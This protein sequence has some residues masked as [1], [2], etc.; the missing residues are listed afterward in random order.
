MLQ[1]ASGEPSRRDVTGEEFYSTLYASRNRPLRRRHLDGSNDGPFYVTR[2]NAKTWT[3]VTPKGLP[4]GGRV[5]YIESSLIAKARPTLL[6]IATC[7]ATI[8]PTSIAPMIMEDLDAFDRRQKWTY[9]MIG[10]HASC[11]K[12]PI[13]KGCCMQSDLW[14]TVESLFMLSSA[15]HIGSLQLNVAECRR[16]PTSYM[17]IARQSSYYHAHTRCKATS[18]SGSSRTTGVGQSFGIHFCRR[19]NASRSCHNHRCDRCQG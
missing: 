18:R 10:P 13:A 6:S 11:A 9:R 19:S 7:S 1:G 17:N 8:Q 16:D 5:Q 12:I 3:N 15:T 2:D 14:G 4:E